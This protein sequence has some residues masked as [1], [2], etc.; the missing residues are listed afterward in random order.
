MTA[1]AIKTFFE[2][3][4]QDSADDYIKDLEAMTQEQLLASQAGAA[5]NPLDFTYEVIVVNGRIAKRLAGETPGPMAEGWAVAPAE[6]RDKTA[7]I[8]AFKTGLAEVLEAWRAL[9]AEDLMKPIMTKSGETTALDMIYMA[10]Y[11]T[12]YHDAQ[13]NYIQSLNGDAEVHW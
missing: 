2:K 6:L 11:H 3:K 10:C 12:G 13:L 5:R 9:P 8:A 4:I 7:I 1:E